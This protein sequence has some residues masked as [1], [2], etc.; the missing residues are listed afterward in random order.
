M[1]PEDQSSA[2]MIQK[3][4]TT[5]THSLSCTSAR[6]G[7][8]KVE[9]ALYFNRGSAAI[10]STA[11]KTSC[12]CLKVSPKSNKEGAEAIPLHLMHQKLP[13]R[14]LVPVD[15]RHSCRCCVSPAPAMLWFQR[16]W[17]TF[18]LVIVCRVS[19]AQKYY[20]ILQRFSRDRETPR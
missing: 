11:R 9:T 16:L 4:Q 2:S 8:G 14:K 5:L 18:L 7:C 19:I 6:Q 17:T 12:T 20:G 3:E 1:T 10:A 15:R 13:E